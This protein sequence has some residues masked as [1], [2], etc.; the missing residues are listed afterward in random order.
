MRK[1][2]ITK[3]NTIIL[4]KNIECVPTIPP[5][6]K[7]SYRRTAHEGMKATFTPHDDGWQPCDVADASVKER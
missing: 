3:L 2:E 5:P 4:H 7:G 6:V 1:K